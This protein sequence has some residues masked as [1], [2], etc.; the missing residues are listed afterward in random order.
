MRERK[1]Q[2]PPMMPLQTQ[3]LVKAKRGRPP[4]KPPTKEVLKSRRK[5]NNCQQNTFFPHRLSISYQAANARERRRMDRMNEA[6][7]R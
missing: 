2:L 7:H 3:T 1:G 5:V 4:S 6:F